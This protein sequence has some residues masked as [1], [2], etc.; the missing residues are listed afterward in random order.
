MLEFHRVRPI[1]IGL[2]IGRVAWVSAGPGA[3]SVAVGLVEVCLVAR[4]VTEPF[5]GK[6]VR[7]KAS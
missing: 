4:P 1:A 3:V 6:A 7:A 2:V 5:S